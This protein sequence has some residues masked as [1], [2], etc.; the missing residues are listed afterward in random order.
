[1]MSAKESS[2]TDIH[3]HFLFG[4]DDGAQDERQTLQ[5]LRQAAE[6]N[7]GRLLATP[8]ALEMMNDEQSELLLRRF[9]EVR[10][11]VR[12]NKLS[13]EIKLAAEIY[14]NPQIYQWLEYPWATFDRRQKYLL[15]E[16]PFYEQPPGVGDFIFQ[17]R[18]KGLVPILA[19]PERYSYLRGDAVKLADWHQQGCLLQ[20][21]AGSIC[22]HFG[23]RIFA[24]SKT[25][26]KA[27]LIHFVASDAHET[28][29]RNYAAL[30]QA[31]KICADFL[32]ESY[33][34]EIFR[35]N[36][37]R[38]FDNLD[39]ESRSVDLQAI[40]TRKDR[41]FSFFHKSLRKVKS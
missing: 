35:E 4:V 8:H 32:P 16:L 37:A 15:F 7:I 41:L 14:F 1:M 28:Q 5:M 31:E 9:D 2:Y 12:E 3:S 23:Q 13:L 26:L 21:N 19:H 11:L 27:G 24:F 18:L 40:Q 36:P 6:E 20:M 38:V 10:E 25:L 34:N 30:P 29:N 22:G 39:V 33:I 17:C